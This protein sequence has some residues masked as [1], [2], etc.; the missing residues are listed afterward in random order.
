MPRPRGFSVKGSDAPAE[1]GACAAAGIAHRTDIS[2]RRTFRMWNIV[3]R[4]GEKG[5]K[6][7]VQD[8]RPSANS[9]IFVTE[10]QLRPVLCVSR[11]WS[12]RFHGNLDLPTP[13][14]K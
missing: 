7:S 4:S 8:S 9:R 12:T 2:E 13:L 5:S 6:K 10:F 14:G 11:A 1:G 3:K